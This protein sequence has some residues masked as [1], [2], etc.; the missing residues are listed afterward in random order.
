[1][2]RTVS[3]ILTALLLCLAAGVQAQI[4][5]TKK[6]KDADELYAEAVQATRAGQYQKA[7]ALSQQALKIRPDFTDQELLLGRLYMLTNNYPAA[8]M[9][10]HKVIKKS[11]NYR[12]AYLYAVNIEMLTR[13]YAQ[14]EKYVNDALKQFPG[15]KE[16][17]LKKLGILDVTERF[18]SGNVYA[19][20]L[21][22]KFTGDTSVR[23]AYVGHYL[24]AGHFY[25]QRG[26]PS[27]AEQ[28]YEKALAMQPG[29]QEAS[30]SIMNMHLK[31]GSYER[32]LE[33]V[34]S[35]LAGNPGSYDLLMR[36]L[37]LLQDMHNYP[38]ALNVLQQV[39]KNHPG[40]AKARGLDLSLRMEAASW[41]TNTD[42]YMLY[43]GILEKNPGNREALDKV[44]GIS[45]ARGAYREALAWINTG[46]KSSPGDQRLQSLKLDV[47]ESDRKFGEAAILAEKLLRS[48]PSA[49]KRQRY[50]ALRVASGRDYLAQQQYDLALAEFESALRE[51]PSDTAALDMTA[52]TYITQ[53]DYPRALDVLNSA[54]AAHPSNARF[55]MKKASVLAET[56]Q[57]DEAAD[58]ARSLQTRFPGNHRYTDLITDMHLTAGRQFMQAEEYTLAKGQFSLVLDNDP[59]NMEAL[60]Y[61]VNLESARQQY[62]SAIYYADIALRLQP[63]NKEM[64]LKKASVYTDMKRYADA[65]TINYQ[66]MQRYPYT[67]KYRTAYV[68]GLVAE[69]L[70]HWRNNRPD[71]A[72]PI[73]QQ[74]LAID[75]KDSL[76]LL[77]SMNIL[78]ARK[79][80][81]S[82]LVYANEALRYYPESENFLQRRALNLEGLQDYEAAAR[83]AD[84]LARRFPSADNK[85]YAD[86]MASK[87]LKNQFGL[88]YLNSNYDYA[89]SNYNIATVE[90][91]RFFKKGS[92]AARANYA[93][94]EEGTGLMG[95]AELY[96]T[97]SK[98]LYS[99][100]LAAYGNKIVFPQLR[101]A[102]S[103]FKTF[104]HE[105]EGELGAR[106]LMTDSTN[107]VTGVTSIAKPFGDFWVN[108]RA[109]FI[110]EEGDFNTSFN[111]TTRYYMNRRQDYLAL[112]A[113]LGTSPDDRS[114]L[115]Q[116][117]ELTGLLTRSIAA[118]YQKTIRYRTTLGLFGTWIN[119]KIGDNQFQNQYDIYITV[120][121]K[122]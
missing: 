69:A 87:G 110:S 70:A 101:L 105:I 107:S 42:P 44:I 1:M 68:E 43:T 31:S 48:A 13:Q 47:L 62:D 97:H 40:D 73:F 76:A 22:E 75:K 106:Y 55:L 104:N 113:G 120:Q 27:L 108:L 79:S 67:V 7:I 14:A 93:G 35:E 66:L 118:G 10:V 103:I 56:G 112:I 72:F 109:Y 96:Y 114:R 92:W 51:S 119:Q 91:R 90:Y 50:I 94:R 3:C 84:T 41:Y 28:H 74:A 121:R 30:S 65:N 18:Q 58:I 95:E 85:D 6:N 54:L 71:S 16:F 17:M 111:L 100:A 11:P 81:D 77:N 122:F 5:N 116:F 15:D 98:S 25:R 23:K 45:L 59:D 33:Q 46:L 9:Y 80:Y 38:E 99:Y 89:S 36:K 37:G 21:L 117:P 4:F 64:L 19:E 20:D 57:Y 82:A 86:L 26:I 61:L 63:D 12:D 8:R 39:L 115:V 83:A 60:N 78:Y 53:K 24:M 29:N 88:F 34:N 52:N 102:Y 49:E 2:K 32:A